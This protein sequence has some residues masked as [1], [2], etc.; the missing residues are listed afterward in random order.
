MFTP[1]EHPDK[2][3]ML[4]DGPKTVLAG[5]LGITATPE[6]SSVSDAAVDLGLVLD[7]GARGK[8][9][10]PSCQA[11]PTDRQRAT[12]RAPDASP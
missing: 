7:T 6:P 5:L 12:A 1:E 8:R 3:N 2:V 10:T 11:R 9:G 4:I